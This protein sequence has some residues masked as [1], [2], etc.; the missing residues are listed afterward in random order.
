M[1]NFKVKSKPT[2]YYCCDCG[3]PLFAKGKTPE[4]R[5]IPAD[6]KRCRECSAIHR[7]LLKYHP[8]LCLDNF[9]DSSCLIKEK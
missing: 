9:A 5:R 3:K 2:K 8:K 1:Q 4:W 7:A 6:Q